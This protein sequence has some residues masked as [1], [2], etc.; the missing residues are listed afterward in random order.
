MLK[1]AGWES[2]KSLI[3]PMCGSGTILIEAALMARNVPNKRSF[4]YEKLL[5]L[6]YEEK[7]LDV[8][9][10]LYGIE[11]FEKHLQGAVRNAANAGVLDT[12]N[13]KL[14]DA[15]KMEGEYD[16][17]V[18]NPPY[19]LR[20]HRKGAIGRLYQR[21]VSAARK[22]MHP[23]S[24]LAVITSEYNLFRKAAEKLYCMHERYVKYGG[25]MTKI[26]VFSP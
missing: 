13:L 3:D 16:F 22:C 7:L 26:L 25:L 21:F 14:G 19:G 2:G 15:T 6:N 9:L 18:T 10:K 8:S 20:I 23:D 5:N 12:I 4:A 1:I 11:K 17:I 24:R